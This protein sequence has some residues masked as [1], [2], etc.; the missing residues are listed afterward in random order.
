MMDG[1]VQY[2]H[3]P[4]ATGGWLA[5]ILATVMLLACTAWASCDVW[6]G[7]GRRSPEYVGTMLAFRSGF[8]IL[9]LLLGL[10][11]L[12]IASRFRF[13]LCRYALCDHVLAVHDPL[14]RRSVS[15]DLLDVRLV[16]TFYSPITP[17]RTGHEVVKQ[18]GSGVQFTADLPICL[19]IIQ[20][21]TNARVEAMQSPWGLTV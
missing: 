16:R 12:R 17:A 4:V 20:Q 5:M 15:V 6:L 9:G 11:V 13:L 3:P 18:D 21:C 1:V 7:Y 2:K 14:L 19:D 10:A 8:V